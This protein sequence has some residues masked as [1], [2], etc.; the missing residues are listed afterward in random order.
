MPR[1]PRPPAL[2]LRRALLALVPA[3][4]AGLA[5][6]APA[7]AVAAA[8]PGPVAP[9]PPD[10]ARFVTEI[11]PFL[12]NYCYDCHDAFERK[13]DVDLE[14]LVDVPASD[15]HQRR[16]WE[17]VF[18]QLRA[19]AMPPDDEFQP[20]AAERTALVAALEHRLSYVDPARARDPGRVTARRFNRLEYDN[21]IR[22]LFG[23]R[24]TLGNSFP[25]DDVGYGF[26]NIGDVHTTSPLR[27]QR[28]LEAAE[29]ITDFLFQTGRRTELNRNEQAVFFDRHEIVKSSDAGVVLDHHSRATVTY[30]VPLPG[31]YTLHLH[32]W[33]LMPDSVFKARAIDELNA[34]PEIPNAFQPGDVEPDVQLEVWVDGTRVDA[35]AIR[36]GAGSR[37]W[38]TYTTTF[39]ATMGVHEVAFRLGVPATLTGPARTAW[40]ADPPRV[41]VR[42]ARLEGPFTVDPAALGP[43]HRL[44]LTTRPGPGLSPAAAVERVFSELLPRAFRRP[45]A[46]AELAAYTH[47]VLGLLDQGESFD[48]ALAGGVQAALISPHFLYRLDHGPDAADPD[49]IRPVGDYALASRLSYFLW[50]SMPDDTLFDLAAAGRLHDPAELAR[51]VRRLLADE[52]AVAF[53]EGFFRQW[54]DLRKLR[55]LTIDRARFPAFTEDLRADVEAETLLFIRSVIDD[56]RPIRDLLTADYTFVNDA[57]ARLYGLPAPEKSSDRDFRRVSLTDLPRRGLLTQPSIL[58]L[59]SYPNRTSPTKRGNWILE[60]IL[61]DEPPPPPPNVPQLEEAAANHAALPLREQLELHRTNQTCASCHATMDP[62]GL[63]LE[64]FDAIGRWRTED[65]GAPIDASG[66]LPGG[67]RFD[68]PLE[69]LDILNQREADFAAAFTRKLLTY[70]LGRGL[71]FYDRVAVDEILRDAAP[72]DHRIVDLVTAVVQSR[73]FRFTRGDEPAAVPVATAAH[74]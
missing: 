68:G 29:T 13:G 63:G 20:T 66:E 33:G 24:L 62:I 10:P 48:S 36:Q 30:D 31:T 69:L 70:A 6:P 57:L 15:A 40:L 2:H 34:W 71:E 61:G 54:L 5:R 43:L 41:G 44:L 7:E 12:E 21:T 32:A 47:L 55:L 39:P 52:R 23:I 37:D 73:P 51:Q 67:V 56:N 11:Q 58:M 38:R 60:A 64:N 59:T 4:A 35:L 27:L 72:A 16:V 8:D 50:A 3:I 53:K 17:A 18:K 74:P 19:G 65:A 46:A 42:E 26:D 28:Y 45:V 25:T 14:S 49:R 1:L 22:D 9:A